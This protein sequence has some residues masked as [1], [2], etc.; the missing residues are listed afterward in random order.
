MALRSRSNVRASFGMLVV[1]GLAFV[2]IIC[3]TGRLQAE[4]GAEEKAGGN[5]KC[6]VCHAGM[7]TEE[8]T[9]NHLAME[10]TCDKCHGPSIE[11]MHDEMLMTEPDVLFGRSQVIAL[12]MKCHDGHENPEKVEAFRQEWVARMRP[13]GRNITDDSVCTDCHGTHNIANKIGAEI[14]QQKEEQWLAA[15]NGSDLTGWKPSGGASWNVR[16]GR[17]YATPSADGKPASLWSDAEY[18]DYLMAVT[19]RVERPVDAGIWVRSDGSRPGVRVEILQNAE[20]KARSGSVLVAEKGLALVNLRSDL[21]DDGGWNTIS[22]KA[23]GDRVQV[24]LNAEEI[25]AV[26][27]GEPTK[28][29]IGLYAAGKAGEF[30]VRE[31]KIKK[32]GKSEKSGE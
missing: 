5:S 25:G 31:V 13:N 15:F 29:R 11:H 22:I 8:L 28:G 6:Y 10:V 2:V 21:L 14:E 20:P 3:L 24:W 7:K 9:T 18:D 30:C 16:M 23:E 27:T 1:A 12:C 26:R 17:I 19:F 4:R 32:L